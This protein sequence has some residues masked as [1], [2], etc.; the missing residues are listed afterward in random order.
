MRRLLVPIVVFVGTLGVLF[1]AHQLRSGSSQDAAPQPQDGTPG[2]AT[3]ADAGPH[4]PI[5]QFS[6]PRGE[7]SPRDA[8]AADITGTARVLDGDTFQIGA[9]RIRV[10]GVDAPEGRQT[11]L[12][13]GRS[14]PCGRMATQA[15]RNRIDGRVVRCEERDRDGRIIALCHSNGED[16]GAWLVRSGWALAFRRYTRA[17]VAEESEAERNSAGLWRGDFV[18]PWDW[19]RGERLAATNRS[20]WRSDD[21]DIPP[22]PATP[23]VV[24]AFNPSCKIKGNISVS[25]GKRWYHMPGGRDY[26]ITRISPGRGERW[27]CTEAEARAAGWTRA[28]HHGGVAANRNLQPTATREQNASCKIKGN[29]NQSNGKRWYHMPSDRDYAITRI[30]TRRGERWFCTEAEARAAGWRRVR[31]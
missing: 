31:N 19:R 18:P 3:P 2:I 22:A 16:V 9:V 8:F 4:Q 5:P 24:A 29:I 26:E 6:D 21:R 30:N 11:C 13:R 27:F 1:A 23:A 25:T 7:I 14:Y 17:Y 20:M 12:D 10:W 15:L 28:G